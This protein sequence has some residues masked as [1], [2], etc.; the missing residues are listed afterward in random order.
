V[1]ATANSVATPALLPDGSVSL[2]SLSENIEAHE[3][4]VP[5]QPQRD[6]HALTG[7]PAR[8]SRNETDE[9]AQEGKQS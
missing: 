1:F 2:D 8:A 3:V 4:N 6:A 7:R 9:R 5:K